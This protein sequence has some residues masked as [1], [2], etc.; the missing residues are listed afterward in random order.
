MQKTHQNQSP[1]SPAPTGSSESSQSN[2]YTS[3]LQYDTETD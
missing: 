1:N 3:E 2:E